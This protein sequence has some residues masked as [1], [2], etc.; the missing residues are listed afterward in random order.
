MH[1]SKRTKINHRE[2]RE[3]KTKRQFVIRNSSLIWIISVLCL[4]G[5]FESKEIGTDSRTFLGLDTP[6]GMIKYLRG[7][8][9]PALESVEIWH[10]EY[11]PGLKLTSKHYEIFTTLLEPSMLSELADFMESA[12]HGYN[13]QLPE[14]IETTTKFTI[15]LFADRGQWEDFTKS[16]AGQQ[17]SV[18]CEI[19]SG[20]YYLNGACVAYDI[21]REQTFSVL[22]HEGWHQ[23]NSRHFRL[24]LPSW[25]DEGIATLFETYSSKQ[26]SFEF[27]PGQNMNRLEALEKVLTKNKMMPLKELIAMN[28]GEVLATSDEAVTAFYSQSYALVRFLREADYGRR[29][30]NYHRLL[31]DGLRGNWPLNEASKRIAANRNIRLTSRWNRA[32]GLLLFEHYISDDFE[33]IEEEYLAFCRKI[34]YPVRL[35]SQD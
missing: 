11:G 5:C 32:I 17:A 20:A 21:G 26:G 3:R 24:R 30:G 10:N 1:H 19:R 9:L 35:K 29:L 23:F 13:S 15:Y 22:G 2:R 18:Y 33:Q 4:S 12:H 16:F 7:Q 31:V 28:P 8:K 27:K 14:P 34:V 6:A 25:L